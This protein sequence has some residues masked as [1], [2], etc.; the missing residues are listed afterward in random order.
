MGAMLCHPNKESAKLGDLIMLPEHARKANVQ[1]EKKIKEDKLAERKV[2]KL[3]LLG[4]IP[5]I[6]SIIN[7]V[8]SGS[9][10]SGKST[11]AKQMRF[12][13]RLFSRSK[14]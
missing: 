4:N 9:S 10:D 8:L 5:F 3:L 13:L 1:I 12:V 11:I 2:V 7:S 6:S 14:G